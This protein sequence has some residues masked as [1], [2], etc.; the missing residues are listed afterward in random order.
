MALWNR[1]P[2]DTTLPK[3]DR[4]SGSFNDYR[5]SLIP[6][7]A[8]VTLRLADSTPHQDELQKI[9]DGG[10]TTLETAISRRSPEDERTDA[11]L[12]VRLF[13]GTRVTGVV[14]TVPRGLESVV[15]EALSRLEKN[16]RKL[17]IPVVLAKTRAGWRVDLLIGQ[18]RD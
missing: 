16:G 9:A 11:P 17:R 3:D 1:G 18:T 4:G 7:N 12:A 2:R 6:N 5:Y 13:A 8:K 10:E 15:D 14:G